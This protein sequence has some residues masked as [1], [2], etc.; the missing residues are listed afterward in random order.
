MFNYKIVN[1]EVIITGCIDKSVKSIIIPEFIDNLPITNIDNYAFSACKY[2]KDIIIPNYVT[3]IGDYAFSY[4]TSLKEINGV[5]LK[6]YINII[7]NRFTCSRYLLIHKIKY[8]IGGDYAVIHDID[9]ISYLIANNP[10][11]IFFNE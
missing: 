9:C 10:Y 5:K 6:E 7:D 1:N 3:N 4:C 11:N 2:L 8:Q